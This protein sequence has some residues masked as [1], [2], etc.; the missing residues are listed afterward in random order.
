M[1]TFFP[2]FG[3]RVTTVPTFLNHTAKILPE[4][5]AKVKFWSHGWLREDCSAL[6]VRCQWDEPRLTLD[7]VNLELVE[8]PGIE[9]LKIKN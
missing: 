9:K 5:W 7:E 4:V 3:S 8:K 6:S 1:P 2:K